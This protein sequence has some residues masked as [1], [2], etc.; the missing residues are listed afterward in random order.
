MKQFDFKAVQAIV[1]NSTKIAS[2]EE[3]C[4]LMAH[5][6]GLAVNNVN[7]EALFNGCRGFLVLQPW[8][9]TDGKVDVPTVNY[10]V[11]DGKYEV[12]GWVQPVK[13]VAAS[14]PTSVSVW[15]LRSSPGVTI[16]MEPINE[17]QET[18][19]QIVNSTTEHPK[20]KAARLIRETT[21]YGE[22]K[23]KVQHAKGQGLRFFV[24]GDTTVCAKQK[25]GYAFVSTA[26]RGPKETKNKIEGEIQAL[27]RMVADKAIVIRVPSIKDEY[28]VVHYWPLKRLFQKMFG[29]IR[30]HF[31]VGET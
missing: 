25:D 26:V 9:T 6:Y 27:N 24:V 4:V 16:R 19:R 10:K 31:Q 7:F 12:T 5:M 18:L 11:V 30:R 8:N 23:A 22:K 13:P 29:T 17:A 2:K 21:G 28:G 1:N 15:T 20:A 14:V 3:V